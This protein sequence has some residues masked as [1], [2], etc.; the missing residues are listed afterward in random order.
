MNLFTASIDDWTSWAQVFQSIKAFEPLVKQIFKQHSLPFSEIE[1][2]IPGT[3]AVFKVGSC[4]V[5]ILAPEESGWNTRSD[6]VTELF[7]LERANKLGIPVPKLLACGSVEDQYRFFYLVTEYV[8]GSSLSR[9]GDRLS[10]FEKREYGR[11]L[12]EITERMHTPCERFNEV[13]IIARGLAS[14]R[15]HRF[16]ASFQQERHECLMQYQVTAPVY[17]HGDLTGDNVILSPSGTLFIIDFA[18]AVLAPAEY[19]LPS[20]MFELFKFD[21]AYFEGYFGEYGPSEL[22]EKCCG[23]LL[24][25]DFGSDMI[26][27]LWDINEITSLAELKERLYRNMPDSG[28]SVG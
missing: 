7:G 18:D 23:A 25:H 26:G 13:D 20:L 10:D 17:V 6:Y 21:K 27:N 5:K 9:I 28:L 14:E 24:V 16:S 3:H 22:V 4:V 2:C 12:R 11:Q 15:W 8:P 19:E 1:Q